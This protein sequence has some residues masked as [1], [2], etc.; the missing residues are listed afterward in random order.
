MVKIFLDPGHGGSDP[1]A[2]GNGLKE[3]DLNL[4]IALK[5][6]DIL[7]NEYEGHDIRMSRN[8]DITKSLSARTDEANA[9][10]A[11]YYLSIHINAGGGTGF[12]SFIYNGNYP[13]KQETDR[14]RNII[15]DTIMQHVDF[16]DRGKKEANF[17]VLRETAM[18]ASLTENGF[19]DHSNDAQKLKSDA[20]LN[21]I[22]RGHAVGLAEALGLQKKEKKTEQPNGEI[23]YRV[24]TGSFKEKENADKRV[25]ELKNAG[26][27]SFIDIFKG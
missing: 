8:S 9:W 10:G 3:K 11:N 26:F 19:I 27:D 17:H 21:K 18:P 13:G 14:L 6:R 15:H 1:G 5:V 4:K 7:N 12:E 25:Q 20:F 16:Q 2:T 23:Y 24:I 22:A